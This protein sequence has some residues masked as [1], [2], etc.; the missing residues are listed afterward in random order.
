MVYLNEQEVSTLQQASSFADEFAPTH[1]TMFV[2]R[3]SSACEFAH[4][5]DACQRPGEPLVTCAPV[6]TLRAKNDRLCF[7]CNKPGHIV[8]DCFKVTKRGRTVKTV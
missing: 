3:D 2:K 1:K 4:K 7:F 5:S 8:A 6:P